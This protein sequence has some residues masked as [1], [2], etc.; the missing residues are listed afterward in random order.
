MKAQT[1]GTHRVPA[2]EAH[3]AVRL[4]TD[5]AAHD[6]GEDEIDDERDGRQKRGEERDAEGDQEPHAGVR[7][8]PR[9]GREP[10]PDGGDQG[11]EGENA[12]CGR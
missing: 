3:D 12:V 1:D 11:E 10:R 6:A 2:R 9:G 4:I 5:L 7:L 8:E